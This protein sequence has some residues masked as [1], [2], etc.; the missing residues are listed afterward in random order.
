MYVIQVVTYRILDT[1]SRTI[2]IICRLSCN[3]EISCQILTVRNVILPVMVIPLFVI[4]LNRLYFCSRISICT[5]N[6]VQYFRLCCNVIGLC[7]FCGHHNHIHRIDHISVI[8][9]VRRSTP[10]VRQPPVH[11][12]SRYG[13]YV[14][15][16]CSRLC[17]IQFDILISS[18]CT[19]TI[20]PVC[21]HL[22]KS[23]GCHTDILHFLIGSCC[24]PYHSGS[25]IWKE[26]L[27]VFVVICLRRNFGI[28]KI[29]IL[30]LRIIWN[31]IFH[32]CDII[33]DLVTID[34]RYFYHVFLVCTAIQRYI[35]P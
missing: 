5:V 18:G 17:C 22:L 27:V 29:T 19:L 24:L 4:I 9:H 31:M 2:L 23:L 13:K 34:G 8:F 7:Q 12:R 25:S 1:A 10:P 35:Q 30:Y 6:N 14:L 26:R 3:E 20:V 28:F 21:T 11:R 15:V 33:S 16:K 32:R